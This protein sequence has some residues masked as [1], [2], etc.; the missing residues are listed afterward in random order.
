ML[1][2]TAAVKLTAVCCPAGYWMEQLS[3][4]EAVPFTILQFS[5]APSLTVAF[6]LPS[7]TIVIVVGCGSGGGGGGGGAPVKVA[8]T[9]WS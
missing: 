8:D 7:P 9:L 1:S 2:P 6:P 3:G 4:L 5:F